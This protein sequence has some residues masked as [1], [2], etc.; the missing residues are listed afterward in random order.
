MKLTL[1]N[2]FYA[3][4]ISPTAQ[5]AASL[6][7][8]RAERGDEVTVVTARIGYLDRPVDH[9]HAPMPNLRVLHL[10]TAGLGRATALRRLVDYLVF[11][12]CAAVRIVLLPAQDVIVSMTTP[13]YIVLAAVGHKLLHPRTKIV[14]WSMDCYPDAAE[15]FGTMRPRGVVSRT[16]RALNRF[17]FRR[18]DEL[19][20]LDTAMVELLESQ[21]APPSGLAAHVIPNWERAELFPANAKPEPWPGYDLPELRD[22]FVVL[23]LGNAGM[24]HRFHTVIDAAKALRDDGVVFLFI[25]GGIRWPDLASAGTDNIV[26]HEY[27][28]KEQTPSVMAGA[29]AALIALDDIALGVMSPSKLHAYLGM[30]LPV[31]YVGPEGSNVDDALARYE[32]GF[33]LRQ[34]DV[35]GLVAAIRSLRDGGLRSQLAER[36]RK[37]FDDAYSDTRALPRFDELLE[38]LT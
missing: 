14:L 33:S 15:R 22:K 38:H 34:G 27:V 1:V 26:L 28:P 29:D 19:V 16:L 32:C 18:V 5:L 9:E 24:G 36:A 6:A 8:H 13:P 31:V 25:G 12:A 35:E 3:P 4:D 21:Y 11:C 7:E 2:Q 23:Y 30:S 20:C 17:A 37:A 10:P